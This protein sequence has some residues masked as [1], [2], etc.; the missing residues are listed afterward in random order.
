MHSP[1]YCKGSYNVM[2]LETNCPG[3]LGKGHS[4][5]SR[6]MII[7]PFLKDLCYPSFQNPFL[8]PFDRREHL[9]FFLLLPFTTDSKISVSRLLYSVPLCSVFF[10]ILFIFCFSQAK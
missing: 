5:N 1:D 2:A 9:S 8:L 4:S 10:Y 7:L 6:V 3:I